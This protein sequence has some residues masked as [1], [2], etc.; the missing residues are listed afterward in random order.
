MSKK[1]FNIVTS[2][3]I[4]SFILVSCSLFNSTTSDGPM[5]L[6][7]KN[8]DPT[9]YLALSKLIKDYGKSNPN[10][11]SNKK[12]YAVFD[13]DNTSAFN[14]VEENTLLYQ[15]ENL[16]FNVTPDKLDEI[17]KKDI[18]KDSFAVKNDE[19]K[20]INI[21]LIATDI[22][23]DYTYLYNNYEGLKGK[24]SL[25]KIKGS[26]QYKD[27]VVK[28]RFLYEAIGKTFSPDVSYPWVIY[29]F[30]GMNKSEV[31][32]L[33]EESIDYW[34]SH[35]V[36]ELHLQSPKEL[37]GKAGIVSLNCYVGLRGIRE[38]Q[39]LYATLMDNGFD[40][41]ICSASFVDVVKTFA[42]TPKYGYNIHEDHIIAMELER[43][44]NGI[45]LDEYRKGY[46]QTQNEGKTKNIKRFLVSKYGYGPILVGG[47]SSGDYAML[48]DFPDTKIG[49]IIN[50]CKDGK[51]GELSRVAVQSKGSMKAKYFLQGRN[52]NN[53]KFIPR[54]ASILY[55]SNTPKL[56][57]SN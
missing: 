35:S 44:K 23:S 33:A 11:N 9:A 20:P 31:Q 3:T 50:R 43:D 38:M 27:F 36:K 30:T 22:I 46:D 14:D 32:K 49:I 45:I 51:I 2:L 24:E 4:A 47:D 6:R 13:W 19:G 28:M 21:D 52:E 25:S 55:G 34:E 15:L 40:V 16:K 56:L 7:K 26:L 17:L 8:W 54:S 41:Y 57:K 29:L 48:K 18:P 37:P 39:N 53:G 10:Y 12:P 5:L 1:R 42:S